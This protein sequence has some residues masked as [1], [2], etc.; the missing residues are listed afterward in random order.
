[1]S[2]MPGFSADASRL[3][4][5]VTRMDRKQAV[6]TD[7]AAGPPFDVI[8]TLGFGPKGNR[9][10]YTALRGAKHCTVL[11]GVQAGYDA[12]AMTAFSPDGDHLAQMVKSDGEWVILV[13]GNKSK[14]QCDQLSQLVL[15]RGGK[16]LALVC[17]RGGR[18]VPIV[19]GAEGKAYDNVGEIVFSGGGRSACIAMRDGRSFVVVDN[20]EI[21]EFEARRAPLVFDGPSSFH[22][23]A[24][25]NGEFF[26]EQV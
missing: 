24:V 4:F 5:A 19:D 25:K 8:D 22:F 1:V 26:R 15:A 3:A 20:V 7:G 9:L 18:Q 10:L 2:G 17:Q 16:H 13:D 23:I 11:D 12:V 14:A 21:G 6:V